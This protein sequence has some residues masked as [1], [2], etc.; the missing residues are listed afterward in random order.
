MKKNLIEKN[1]TKLGFPLGLLITSKDLNKNYI[2]NKVGGKSKI[3]LVNKGLSSEN[4][5]FSDL[6]KIYN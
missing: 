6:K 4:I 2:L 3:K 5:E 1:I